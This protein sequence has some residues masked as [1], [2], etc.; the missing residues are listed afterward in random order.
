VTEASARATWLRHAVGW[1]FVGKRPELLGVAVSGGSDSMALLDL[2][3][4]IGR[5]QGFE[6]RAVTV[7]HGLRAEASDEAAQ[8]AAYCRDQGVGHDVLV[9]NG[10]DKRGNLQAK[11]RKAR[12]GLISQWAERLGVDIVALGHTRDDQAETVVMRLAR[13]SGVDGLAAMP[14]RFVRDGL[15]FVRPLLRVQREVLR[16]YLRDRDVTWCEDPSNEDDSFERVRARKAMAVLGGLGIDTDA[17]V[18]VAD[19]ARAAKWA[20]DHY[21]WAEVVDHGLVREIGG[22]IILPR[23]STAARVVPGEV[24]RRLT[25][26]AAMWISGA[27]YPLRRETMIN[28]EVAFIEASRHTAAGCVFS[29]V[30]AKEHGGKNLRICREFNAVKGMACPSD[31]PWDGRWTLDGP[32][33]PGLE[34][35]ALGEAVKDCPEWRE[36]GMPR[37]SL[38]ASPAVWRGDELVAAPVAG[39][40]NGWTAE[41]TGRGNFA[42]FLLSR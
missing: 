1:P 11:A 8:V 20:L 29:V 3:I 24:V 4:W 5:D 26:A 17:L 6:V 38:L 32:H 31:Q 10:W 9:W 25:N 37:L 18:T 21:A 36:T 7:D 14:E 41:A 30:K 39:F 16:D 33:E 34:I 28:M 15:A 42:K 22:D 40:G 23:G 13:A 12:Y 35:R 19:N 27:A 2:M